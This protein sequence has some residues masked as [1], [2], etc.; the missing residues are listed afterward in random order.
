MEYYVDLESTC[1]ALRR[2][3]LK[4]WKRFDETGERVAIDNSISH[5]RIELGLRP[6]G[7]PH[8]SDTMDYLGT[9]L[10]ERFRRWRGIEDLE[11]AIKFHRTALELR[12]DGHPDR[13]ESLLKL[14]SSLKTRFDQLGGTAELDEAI[15]RHRTAL[16]LFPN[17]HPYRSMSLNNLANAL[18]TRFRQFG[19]TTDIDEAIKFH[20]AALELRPNGHPHRCMSLNN[21]ANSF[22]NRFEQ[23]GQPTD[24]DEAIKYHRAALQ[25]YPERHPDR[26]LSLNNLAHSL[27]TRFDQRG[28]TA[29]LDEAIKNH[30]AALELRPNGHPHRS[31]SLNNL[32]NSLQAQFKL[33]GQTVDLDE[34]IKYRR[35]A[36]QLLPNSHP[37]RPMCLNNLASSLRTRFEQHGQ[38]QD[39][40]E[41]IKHH[42]AAL[43]I[44]LDGHSDRSMFLNN[45]AGS[46][47]TRFRQYGRT[48]DLDEAIECHRAALE[49][50]P[51]SHPIRSSSLNNLASSLQTRFEQYGQAADNNEAIKYYRA[52]L[53][54]FPDGHPDR[55]AS[56]NNLAVSLQ[57]RFE[58][59]GQ[60]T[61]LDEA[62]K[63]YRAAL[64]LR[65][66]GHNS[67]SMSLN[68]LASSLRIRFEQRGQTA[69]IDESIEYHRAALQ[70]YPEGHPD[71]SMSLNNLANSL[72]ARFQKRGLST[73]LD[74]AIKHHR[75][76]LQSL[77][78]G[79]PV[80][81]A[82]QKNLAKSLLSRFEKSGLVDDFE[83]CIQLLEH[84]ADHKLSSLTMRLAAASQW[85]N[86]AGSHAHDTTSRAYKMVML[87]LQRALVV[88]PN[89][90]AQHEL[91][92]QGRYYRT[93]ALDAA[94]H[95]VEG[96]ILEDAIEML[97]QGRGLLWSQMRGFRT[98][99]DQLM[100]TNREL[101][102][103]FSSVSHR[104]ERLT[105]SS[106]GWT[107]GMTLATSSK[108]L[109]PSG[110][111]DFRVHEKQQSLDKMLKLKRQVS[112]EQ[113]EIIDEIRRIPGFESFLKATP[114]KVLQQVASE[115]P[116]IVVNHSKYRS[117]A[118]IILP[119]EDVP[120]VCVPLDGE[121][122]RDGTTLYVELLVTRK[123]LGPGSSEYDTKLLE[124]M[125]FLW[126]RVV[127]KVVNKLKEFGII[128]GSRIWW[129]PTSVLSVL[130]F[131]AAGPFKGT[132]GTI[133]Y[134]LDDYVSSY[135][136]TLGAL[137]SA[138]SRE[139]KDDPTML[140]VG[141]TK[142][143][144]STEKEIRAVRDHT[145]SYISSPTIFL[146]ERAC[147]DRVM[148]RL[149][150]A[151]WV[152]F[153]CHGHLGSGSLDSSFVLSD[154]GL[155]LLDI[156]RADLP[157]AEFAFLS[158]CHTAEQDGSGSY[159]EVLHLASAAQFC[160]FRS[161]IGTMWE[162][163][164]AD[165][166]L[167]ARKVYSYMA[168]YEDGEVIHKRS[169]AA[170]R[171]AILELRRQDGVQT[172]RW[173]NLVHIGA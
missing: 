41:A 98:P 86:L 80:R 166:P 61:D 135:T 139:Y 48:A 21:L 107:A 154:G 92:S 77:P 113:D 162:L 159:D 93:F 7:H 27:Q 127:S 89:L 45:L 96:E 64:E 117:D 163:Y 52:A 114:F 129:C 18:R 90:H 121:F 10:D 83:E 97:E 125:K 79:H 36:L 118:L 69:D 170:L 4:H 53:D 59:Y 70:L 37:Y 128:E 68:N 66:N 76:A 123:R 13:S 67:R 56:L 142:S 161:V 147:R 60:S 101:A 29:D 91:L 138:R 148:K 134:L 74:E 81:S 99:L 112:N 2:L 78:E 171:K 146:N 102:E 155:T 34:A 24:L 116:V 47:Q 131:H 54:L 51:D 44:C 28:R 149:Q 150:K 12:P 104:L 62:I 105:T 95:A 164:D 16:Q 65:P 31:E 9:F 165:G 22:Q 106:E 103:R 132:D 136:P 88:S 140:V 1:R 49:H 39:L 157:N 172:E 15:E 82:S 85:A 3:T 26:S 19:R 71:R 87:L 130:P 58:Q 35:A 119:Y 5:C 17:G 137:I 167:L 55:P 75:A 160:G 168:E 169:A 173:V 158:A 72:E 111:F 43:Q 30:H 6:Q 42:R 110:S 133:K 109:I 126:D 153:A 141:D 57:T 46:L 8:R 115:G 156:I 145:R 84:A 152:H 11:E 120:V 32:A 14:A 38:T 50:L 122:H 143:L 40:D 108:D 33:C 73:D 124:A 20:R 100:E 94:A 144:M 25:L 151:T 23:F 63:Y